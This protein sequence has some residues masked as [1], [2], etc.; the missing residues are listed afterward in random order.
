MKVSD[1]AERRVKG[2]T[3]KTKGGEKVVS[4]VD[5]VTRFILE[6]LH[7]P[8]LPSQSDLIAERRNEEGTG[9]GA[10]LSLVSFPFT[11]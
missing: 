7:F 1:C 8:L 2:G 9:G 5:K 6:G 3:R 4:S 11:R 10:A